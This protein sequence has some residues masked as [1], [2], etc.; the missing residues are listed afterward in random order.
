MKNLLG[1]VWMILLMLDKGMMTHVEKVIG[2]HS[3]TSVLDTCGFKLGRP[4]VDV[5]A[6]GCIHPGDKAR[7]VGKGTA[8]RGE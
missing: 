3:D 8:V 4:R 2:V 6:G 5:G 1:K 7:A